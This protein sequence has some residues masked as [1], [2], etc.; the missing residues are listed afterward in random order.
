[1]YLQ[2]SDFTISCQ[3]SV[4]RSESFPETIPLEGI[5]GRFDHFN[6]G[7][8]QIFVAAFGSNAVE[9]INIRRPNSGSANG[10][11]SL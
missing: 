9:A 5:K 4:H 11:R 1:V 7:G 8:G 6:F 3:V 2:Y 10:N